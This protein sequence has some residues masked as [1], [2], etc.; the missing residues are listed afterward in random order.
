MDTSWRAHMAGDLLG[1][2]LAASHSK[3]E[4]EGRREADDFRRREQRDG[5]GVENALLI[6]I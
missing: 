6:L 3:P 5:R 2:A 1:S 4:V